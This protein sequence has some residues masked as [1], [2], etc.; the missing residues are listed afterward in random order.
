MKLANRLL[1]ANRGE[2][3][4]RI[5]RTA[6]Q[7]GIQTIAIHAEDDA[8]SLHV[9]QADDVCP[10]KGVGT[11]AHL[12]QAQIIETAKSNG[13]D[14]IHPGYGFLS[15]N[16]DFAARCRDE[17]IIFVGPRADTLR[18]LGD[19]IQ[20][21]N[22]A[23]DA[24]IPVLPATEGGTSL[25]AAK[26]FYRSLGE[27]GAMMLKAVAGGGG[28]GMRIVRDVDELAEALK[29]CAS[30][31]DAA[32]GNGDL[33]AEALVPNALHIEVQI[34]ADGDGGVSHLYERD[35]SLQRRHQKV[36]EI[37]P[38]PQLPATLR[39]GIL[40]AAI[41]LASQADYSN[42]GTFEFLVD[43]SRLDDQSPRAGFGHT[44]VTSLARI[45]GRPIGIVASNNVYKGGAVDSDGADKAARFMKLCDNFNI[46]ILT[47]NDCPGIM[48]G[49]ED[50]KTALV[51]HAGRM[52]IV[53]ASVT[54][55]LMTV[56]LR[57]SYGL[58]GQA[59]GL[60]TY[61]LPHTVVAWP[62]AEFGPMGL[63]G[64][65]KLGSIAT[66]QAIEDPEERQATYEKLVARLYELGKGIWAAHGFEVDEMIDPADTRKWIIA[67]L[68]AQPPSKR[69]EK[70]KGLCVDA[71]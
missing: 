60:G 45:E 32:F 26:S 58:G 19:K 17:N 11:P 6:G 33:Y 66:L 2:I 54:V 28:R 64:Q 69:L 34:I 51:R 61:N 30:E 5:A 38:S 62:T 39:S 59:M 53:A 22:I 57:K 21:R 71:W 52:F 10:L 47:L 25:D 50:E 13:C 55:P 8:N 31:A 43:G 70:P 48:V 16:A 35:C 14:A 44:T 29:R 9:R 40:N 65:V 12:D 63:E 27:N 24:K 23:K 20:A 49:P 42:I 41:D 1:I 67:C 46:P 68:K 15:E 4:I 3:A 7:L 56:V 18:L 37:A 36:I